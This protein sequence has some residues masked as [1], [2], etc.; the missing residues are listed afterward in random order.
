MNAAVTARECE[1]AIV[2]SMLL[3]VRA[4]EEVRLSP[5]AFLYPD[6]RAAFEAVRKVYVK[7]G[8]PDLLSVALELGNTDAAQLF[9]IQAAESIVNASRVGWYVKRLT[10][11]RYAVRFQEWA[12]KAGSASTFEDAQAIVASM[13]RFEGAH[14][15]LRIEDVDLPAHQ[16]GVLTGFDCLD[17]VTH[18]SGFVAGQTFI[19]SGYQ[20]SGKTTMM[21]QSALAIAKR[22]EDVIYGTFADLSPAALLQKM[23]QMETGHR[24]VQSDFDQAALDEIKALPIQ[25]YDARR[26][27]RNVEDFASKAT[28]L[29]YKY[30]RIVPFVDYVQKVRTAK[31]CQSQVER[32]ERVSDALCDLADTLHVPV[33]VGSQVTIDKDGEA[34]TKYARA[35]E[36][37]AGTVLR[38]RRKESEVT[39]EVP[40]NRHGPSERKTSMRWDAHYLRFEEDSVN[41]MR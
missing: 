24:Q 9:L 26:F 5:D 22:G 8:E 4:V 10:E 35:V 3:S 16:D 17:R 37:D 30:G 15:T 39:W 7:G 19:A 25:F 6:T 29:A 32:V 21:C 11:E 1:V 20:K 38:I 28:A 18:G 41:A 14:E 33:V 34:T 40:F 2:G 27:G 36:E 31:D 13:P 12:A 23:F